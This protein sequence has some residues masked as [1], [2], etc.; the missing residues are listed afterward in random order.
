MKYRVGFVTNSSSS[1]FISV[2]CWALPSAEGKTDYFP[3]VRIGVEAEEEDDDTNYVSKLRS[4]ITLLVKQYAIQQNKAINEK[5]ILSSKM[6]RESFLEFINKLYGTSFR[7]QDL[8]ELHMKYSKGF[9]ES[10]SIE[11]EEAI[12]SMFQYIHPNVLGKIDTLKVKGELSK[13][14]KV[15][16]IEISNNKYHA[17]RLYFSPTEQIDET[18]NWMDS[19][20][21]V[22]E[23]LYEMA[24]KPSLPISEML[25]KLEDYDLPTKEIDKLIEQDMQILYVGS[26]Y[27]KDILVCRSST[28]KNFEIL[29]PIELK[30]T[31]EAGANSI[32]DRYAVV[33][34]DANYKMI[35]DG[36]L[37]ESFNRLVQQEV[38]SKY[39]ASG[40]ISAQDTSWCFNEGKISESY[41]KQIKKTI[42]I[43]GKSIL[44]SSSPKAALNQMEKLI[45]TLGEREFYSCDFILSNPD[46]L[47]SDL[48]NIPEDITQLKLL[49]FLQVALLYLND[50]NLL[51]IAMRVEKKK[52]GLLYKG[53]ILP[54]CWC[55][56]ATGDSF[57]ALRAVNKDDNTVVIEIKKVSSS[58]REIEKYKNLPDNS[59]L[60]QKL[61]KAND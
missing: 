16:R 22:F 3:G 42:N 1:S 41:K 53:R 17:N 59:K 29:S 43:A 2:N 37:D 33:H 30:P 47:L 34:H 32:F 21:A 8:L 28:A 27:W 40:K 5:E 57:H 13:T 36:N 26:N 4:P 46:T 23:Y 6:N 20:L 25:K 52:N 56:I 39:A 35:N 61:K 10:E 19:T 51:D 7:D 45:I 24:G 44:F 50:E 18:T 14:Y 48:P 54:L 60:I 15:R 31:Q 38:R 55:E 9:G 11:T 12:E 49:E 58:P